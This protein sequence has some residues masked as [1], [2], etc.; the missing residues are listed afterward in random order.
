MTVSQHATKSV[1]RALLAALVL[2]L[3]AA[4]TTAATPDP[5]LAG[6][7]NLNTASLEELQL[8][9]G[10]GEVRAQAILARRSEQGGFESVEQLVEVKG[11]G[12]ALLE[13]LRPHLAVKGK[14]T[15]RRL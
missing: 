1:V 6:V 13:R 11:I 15:A 3:S 5:G 14:T 4:T 10:V 9:P 8:L 7:V 2:F 12:P